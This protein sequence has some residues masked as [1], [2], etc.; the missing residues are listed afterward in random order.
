MG[1]RKKHPRFQRTMAQSNEEERCVRKVELKLPA[2]MEEALDEC[3]YVP[4]LER[5]HGVEELVETFMCV[6]EK[7]AALTPAR[8]QEARLAE[9]EHVSHL[10]QNHPCIGDSHNLLGPNELRWKFQTIVLLM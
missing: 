2:T 8:L 4:L 1:R 9:R 5:G 3:F 10:A 7:Q 6:L